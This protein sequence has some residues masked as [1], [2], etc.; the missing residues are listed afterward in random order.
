MRIGVISD[1]HLTSLNEVVKS[2][3]EIH[4]ADVDIVVHAGDIVDAA[5][6]DVFGGRDVYAVCGNMD[7]TSV[8]RTCPQKL[9]LE[10]DWCR[11]GVIHG[12]G[13]PFDIEE[14]LIKE[15]NHIDCL[16][17]GHTHRAANHERGDV[18]YFNPGSPTDGA[19]NDQR[20]V[21]ILE[22]KENKSIKGQIIELP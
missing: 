10:I 7:L 4:F 6:L 1:T 15:F 8:R 9:V 14:K 13:A 2:V 21:G 16:I 18:L 22:I 3:T 11:I 17:Y 5:I 19:F 20:T 12:W